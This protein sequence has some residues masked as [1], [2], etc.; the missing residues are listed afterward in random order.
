MVLPAPKGKN[1]GQASSAAA[2]DDADEPGELTDDGDE[3]DP[4][5]MITARST[6]GMIAGIVLGMFA[7]IIIGVLASMQRRKRNAGEIDGLRRAR[8]NRGT[9]PPIPTPLDAT[10]ANAA[11]E[12]ESYEQPVEHHYGGDETHYGGDGDG[13]H[14]GGDQPAYAATPANDRYSELPQSAGAWAEDGLYDAY[15]EVGPGPRRDDRT[16]VGDQDGES[17][18]YDALGAA[19]QTYA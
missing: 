3:P 12:E 5:E 10:Y 16:T 7:L 17:A 19:K 6:G 13:D 1:R 8:A 4:G 18:P 9:T 11:Y 15:A 14:Y 2:V